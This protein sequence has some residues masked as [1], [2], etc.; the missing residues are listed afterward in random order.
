MKKYLILIILSIL[1]ISLSVFALPFCCPRGQEEACCAQQGR[2]Y[3]PEEGVCRT[4]CLQLPDVKC[5]G[6]VNPEGKCCSFCPTAAVCERMGK[7]QKIIDG[8]YQCVE[9]DPNCPSPH[10]LNEEGT[11]CDSCPRTC[12]D[13]QCLTAVDGCYTCEECPTETETADVITNDTETSEPTDSTSDTE[14]TDSTETTEPTDSTDSTN[15]TETTDST[16]ST[17]T[18]DACFG[19]ECSAGQECCGGECIEQCTEGCTACDPVTKSCKSKCLGNSV[20]CKGECHSVGP[21]VCAWFDYGTCTMKTFPGP[22]GVFICGWGCAIDKE[23]PYADVIEPDW[24]AYERGAKSCDEVLEEARCECKE[25]CVPLKEDGA[26]CCP[27]SQSCMDRCCAEGEECGTGYYYSSSLDRRVYYGLCCPQGTVCRDA[28]NKP[29]CCGKNSV[30]RLGLKKCCAKDENG[31]YPPVITEKDEKEC[32]VLKEEDDECAKVVS[33]C[34]EGQECCN[35]KCCDGPCNEAGDDC[36]CTGDEAAVV[37]HQGGEQV[38]GEEKQYTCCLEGQE[39]FNNNQTLENECCSGKVYKDIVVTNNNKTYITYECCK[40]GEYVK[41][42]KGSTK[43]V[44]ACCFKS[45]EKAFVQNPSD[46][47]ATIVY[48]PEKDEEGGYTLKNSDC[49]AFDL[50][51]NSEGGYD[52]CVPIAKWNENDAEIIPKAPTRVKGRDFEI[53][54]EKDQDAYWDGK[55][56]QCCAGTAYE[57]KQDE[58]EWYCCGYYEEDGVKKVQKAYWNGNSNECCSG[59][60]YNNGDGTYTCCPIT[61]YGEDIR[62]KYLFT[63]NIGLYYGTCYISETES[64]ECCRCSDDQV[65]NSRTMQCESCPENTIK[66][67]CTSCAAQFVDTE[68]YNGCEGENCTTQNLTHRCLQVAPGQH[69]SCNTYTFEGGFGT[70]DGCHCSSSTDTVCGVCDEGKEFYIQTM[71]CCAQPPVKFGDPDMFAYMCGELL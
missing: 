12:P 1:C 27:S 9:C 36:L 14:T 2:V 38:Q 46:D 20:C 63:T 64:K 29:F 55:E 18:T 15:S 23:N 41:A 25:G 30:C 32:K 33:K 66:A 49:C 31:H 71:E 10:C 39:A 5:A 21:S 6:C 19:V 53:C 57:K 22:C 17:E 69:L 35:G 59:E 4:R 13:G 24:E 58:G 56:A 43:N 37:V 51:H 70:W 68:T 34:E 16:D 50:A 52:C 44:E 26:Q 61:S 11:C 62:G 42:A 54:C 67:N 65:W 60:I 3:C 7:C 47:V 40:E 45:N 8:C 48:Y 28:E